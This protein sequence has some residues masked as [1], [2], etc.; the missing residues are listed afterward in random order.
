M[1]T[2]PLTRPAPD[3]QAQL[4]NL[5]IAAHTAN[6]PMD[7]V[8]NLVERQCILAAIQRRGNVTSASVNLR[9]QPCTIYRAMKRLKL[10]K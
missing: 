8:I 10:A 6:V 2:Q 5:E 1:S 7:E 3:L 9:K 4:R